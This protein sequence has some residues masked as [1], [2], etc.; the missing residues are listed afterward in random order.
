MKSDTAEKKYYIETYG[1]QMNKYD[2]E[3]IAGILESIGY[4]I[5]PHAKEADLIL[6]NTCSVREHAESRAWGRLG[7]TCELKKLKPQLIVGVVGCMAQRIGAQILADKPFLNFALGPDNYRHLP[8]ILQELGKTIPKK[9]RRQ[10]TAVTDFE[11]YADIYPR[12]TPG[13]SAWVAIMRGCNNFCAYCIVPYLRGRER[14]RKASNVL[15]EVARLV[16]EGF[17]EVTLLGQN[18]N[19]YHDGEILFPELLRQVSRTPGLWRVRFASSHPKDLSRELIQVMAEEPTICPHI[20]LAVQ[21]G[22]DRILKSM[23]RHY[24]RAHFL[25]LLTEARHSVPDIRFTTDIIVGFPGE[26]EAD[27]QATLDLVKQARFDNAFT[28]KYDPRAG[29]RAAELPETVPELEKQQ[30]L[31][32]LI[33]LQDQITREINQAQI[34]RVFPVLIDGPSKKSAHHFKGRTATNKIVVFRNQ[35]FTAGTLIAAKIVAADGH[36]LFG[37]PQ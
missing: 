23:N 1:C 34:G 12:R 24:T 11:D 4:E 2:S 27:F 6:I 26:T 20:H 3:L 10:Q 36:T 33:Q 37:E 25:N 21:S 30:R 14:S 29:T 13:V 35:Q 17:R 15:H 16:A 8:E 22:S 7:A 19:S 31:E 9:L 5:T 28:F 18:V 32:A